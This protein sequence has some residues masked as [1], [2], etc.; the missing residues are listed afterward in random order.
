MLK[1]YFFQEIGRT[2]LLLVQGT[3]SLVQLSGTVCNSCIYFWILIRID[4]GRLYPD[5]D[6][7]GQK[8]PIKKI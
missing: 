2:H 5:P 8:L 3:T 6:P 4:F 7:G 1:T